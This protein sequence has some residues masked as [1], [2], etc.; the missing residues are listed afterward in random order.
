VAPISAAEGEAAGIASAL[1]VKDCKT[2]RGV[3]VKDIQDQLIKAG[4]IIK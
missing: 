4:A 1:A 3:D 2:P